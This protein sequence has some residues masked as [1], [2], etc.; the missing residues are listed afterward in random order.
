[1]SIKKIVTFF[2]LVTLPFCIVAQN[3][4]T[5]NLKKIAQNIIS[6]NSDYFYP[7]LYNRYLK[8]D[9]TLN[10]QEKQH[11]Y[12]GQLFSP[13][14]YPYYSYKTIDS[15]KVI[16]YHQKYTDADLYQ[17]LSNCDSLLN[18]LPF[19]LKLLFH[20]S[21]LLSLLE[22]KADL[23]ITRCQILTILETIL[24]TGDGITSKNPL[25]V[26]SLEDE[27]Q[28]LKATGYSYNKDHYLSPKGLDYLG[29]ETNTNAIDGFYFSLVNTLIARD[30][31]VRKMR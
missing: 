12:F 11:L 25:F 18:L 31:I 2:C 8:G 20:K 10:T 19:D 17:F 6:V 26:I 5:P 16:L 23:E 29:V 1:M 21:Q 3:F 9:L 22:L 24:S 4:T 30:R 28:F 14:Y 7:K 13:N 27:Y 15:I